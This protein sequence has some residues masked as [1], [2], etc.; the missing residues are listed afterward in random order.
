MSVSHILIFLTHDEQVIGFNTPSSSHPTSQPSINTPLTGH[1]T[2]PSILGYPTAKQGKSETGQTDDRDLSDDKR[3]DSLLQCVEARDLMSYGMIPEFVGRFPVVVSLNHLD[4]ESLVNI[5][6][7]PKNALI[8][9]FVS[10]FKMDQ[11][12]YMYS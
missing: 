3:I 4:V 12:C 1:P 6:S 5:L 10:L 8:P 11:V 9:Q 7:Q 2:E